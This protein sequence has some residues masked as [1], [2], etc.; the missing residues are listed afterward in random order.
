MKC[1][2]PPKP[3]LKPAGFRASD[4][5]ECLSGQMD[6]YF[7]TGKVTLGGKC[8]ATT[9]CGG[10]AYCDYQG[11]CVKGRDVGEKCDADDF[12]L[13][14]LACESGECAKVASKK[15]GEKA[16]NPMVCASNFVNSTGVCD[17]GYRLKSSP[18]V[19]NTTV[20][21]FY[22]QDQGEHKQ[23]QQ[24]SVCGYAQSGK[25]VCLPGPLDL[26]PYFNNVNID[27]ISSLIYE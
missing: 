17:Y 8:T 1:E 13:V 20:P 22:A 25:A 19:D 9:E 27:I 3:T 2:A 26:Q 11:N 16:V 12:C 14:Y 7:C 24:K 18:F 23:I 21:C 10:G 4:A 5:S 6:G 15:V